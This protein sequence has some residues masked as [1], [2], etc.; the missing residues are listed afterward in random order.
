MKNPP[1]LFLYEKDVE[2]IN[3]EGNNKELE[4]QEIWAKVFWNGCF[5]TF[6]NQRLAADIRVENPDFPDKSSFKGTT[7]VFSLDADEEGLVNLMPLLRVLLEKMEE[8][9]NAKVLAFARG[10]TRQFQF[11]K[12]L[13]NT[14]I[15]QGFLDMFKIKKKNK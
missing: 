13:L 11:N 5:C 7:Y 9:P 2:S 8:N 14:L 15:P 4:V 1:R 12:D 6:H 3:E 10:F